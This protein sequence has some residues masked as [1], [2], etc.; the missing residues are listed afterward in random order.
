MA[1]VVI[2]TCYGGFGLS[3][4]ALR[5]LA[6]LGGELFEMMETPEVYYHGE[7][8]ESRPYPEFPGDKALTQYATQYGD[9]PWYL[10]MIESLSY[11]GRMLEFNGY[12]Y[13]LRSHPELVDMVER[14]G[15]A[16]N[17]RFAKLKVIE[18]PDDV[19]WVI[20]EY[21]GAEWIAERHRKWS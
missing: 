9:D 7:V 12:E 19:E 10:G 21:D 2:S 4:K 1:K 20:E 14:L 6:S 16:A 8:P 18:I 3:R 5:E 13:E 11:N 17:G 15:E